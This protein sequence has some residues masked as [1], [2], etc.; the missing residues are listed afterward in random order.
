M[1][2][3]CGLSASRSLGTISDFSA[4]PGAGW[5]VVCDFDGTIAEVDVTDGILSRFAPPEWEAVEAEWKAGHITSRECMQRQIGLLRAP[6]KALDEY[7]DSVGIDPEFAGFV[8]DCRRARLPLVVVSDGIDYAITRILKRHG[9]GRLPRA[10]NRLLASG[11]GFRLEFPYANLQCKAGSGTCKCAMSA[12]RARRGARRLLIGDGSSD[13]CLAAS[14]DL[15]F[16]KSN[17]LKH[18]RERGLSHRACPDFATARRLL[19]DL[20]REA[21]IFAP[22]PAVPALSTL[23]LPVPPAA[24]LEI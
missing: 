3:S 16:A 4:N 23:L 21:P 11:E 13:F 15:V 18:C 24:V 9:L 20:P 19:A 1:P 10:S 6:R 17:L 12:A 5:L 22:S 14:A 2:D 7:L 8:A